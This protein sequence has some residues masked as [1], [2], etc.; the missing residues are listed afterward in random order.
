M[1]YLSLYIISNFYNSF[2]GII[3]FMF[4]MVVN[5]KIVL[6]LS[7]SWVNHEYSWVLKR[8]LNFTR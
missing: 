1:L 8:V 7:I 3:L 6:A 2:S 5:R 4:A